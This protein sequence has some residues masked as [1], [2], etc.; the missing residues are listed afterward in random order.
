MR[1]AEGVVAEVSGLAFT[2][3]AG[4]GPRLPG[5]VARPYAPDRWP[6]MMRE[7]I[8]RLIAAAR[9]PMI[10]LQIV[11]V[12]VGVHAGLDGH[13]ALASVDGSPDVAYLDNALAG[14]VVER[15]GDVI[16]VALLYGMLKAEALSPRAC[17][18]VVSK[19]IEAWT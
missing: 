16:R 5:T 9:L 18:D 2:S 7:Q 3:G 15:A 17:V 6:Q 11:P 19:A 10:V 12:G 13:F 4:V 1:T 14:Q 8:G